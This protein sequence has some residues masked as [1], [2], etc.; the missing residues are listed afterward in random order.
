VQYRYVECRVSVDEIGILD[1]RLRGRNGRRSQRGGVEVPPVDAVAFAPEEVDYEAL[2][3][4][5]IEG[6]CRPK[7]GGIVVFTTRKSPEVCAKE[8]AEKI[9]GSEDR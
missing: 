5:W 2:F 4:R 3:R 6:P 9:V 8:I 7:G 1:E